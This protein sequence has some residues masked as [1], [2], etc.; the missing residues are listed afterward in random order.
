MVVTH[1]ANSD[2]FAVTTPSEQEI[3]MTRLF[4]AP[5]H[6][7]FEA[8]TRPEHVAKWWGC[9]GE[10]YSVPVCEIDLRVGGKW[11]FVSRHPQR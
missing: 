3:R 7:V 6:L 4:N 5:R 11:R 8:M 9:L 2:S 1:A 10:G